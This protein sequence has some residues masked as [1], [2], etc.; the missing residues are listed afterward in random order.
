MT[1]LGIE[2]RCPGP[3]ANTL[4]IVPIAKFLTQ[5]SIWCRERFYRQMK[6]RMSFYGNWIVSNQI[7]YLSDSADMFWWTFVSHEI[8][9]LLSNDLFS[10]SSSVCFRIHHT[11]LGFFFLFVFYFSCKTR[12]HHCIVAWSPP[13][14]DFFFFISFQKRKYFLSRRWK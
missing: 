12:A 9:N 7:F 14:I 11:R 13:C 6:T 10:I 3:L 4:T 1:L 5:S 2:P 8:F